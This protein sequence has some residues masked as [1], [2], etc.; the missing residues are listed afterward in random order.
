MRETEGEREKEDLPLN[1]LSTFCDR[2]EDDFE[3]LNLVN[4]DIHKVKPTLSVPELLFHQSIYI[5]FTSLLLRSLSS[6]AFEMRPYS[7]YFVCTWCH[8]N[9]LSRCQHQTKIPP[10]PT[11]FY[12]CTRFPPKIR[13][14][15]L[16]CN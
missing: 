14:E 10:P 2:I 11:F 15:T 1:Y 6:V 9:F 7:L 3:S 4:G 8:P 13:F 5:H 12:K 16:K